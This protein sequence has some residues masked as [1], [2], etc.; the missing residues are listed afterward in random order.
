MKISIITINFNNKEGLR[1]TIDSVTAQSWKDFEWIIID[2]GSTDGSKDL[3]LENQSSFAFWCS[4]PDKGI[5]NAMNKGIGKATGDYLLFLNSGDILY[6]DTTLERVV[7]SGLNSDIVS[8]QMV[9]MDNG[10]PLRHYHS[11][12]V[13]QLFN[14]TLNHQ[15]SFIR[16]EL[17][18]AIP[19]DESLKIV[20][21]WKFWWESIVFR[22]C[23]FEV[24]DL[25]I[26]KQDM[27]GISL[28]D[29]NKK[30][31]LAERERVLY[32]FFPPLVID[33]LQNYNA[34]RHWSTVK[35]LSYLKESHHGI[36]RFIKKIISFTAVLF[37]KLFKD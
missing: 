29:K 34:L 7:S 16:R 21:D 15:A 24:S 30:M 37:H 5:Y 19:Y 8:G 23:S 10:H 25:R 18:L 6:D 32:S 14:G 9:R 28:S 36:Y 3:I 11:D 22:Q 4:E 31:H 2:G 27:T 33:S 35:N 26:S 12:I 17:L 1:K 13:M 20:S